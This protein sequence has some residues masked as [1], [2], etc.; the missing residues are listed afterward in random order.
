MKTKVLYYNYIGEEEEKEII[1]AL[2]DGYAVYVGSNCIGHTRAEMV[3]IQAERIFKKV[4][5]VKAFKE[6]GMFDFYIMN[7]E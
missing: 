6:H 5:A 1:D 7:A 3:R 4:N 2:N